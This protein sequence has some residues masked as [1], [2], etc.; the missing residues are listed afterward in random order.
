MRWPWVSRK[1]FDLVV[2]HCIELREM[3][4]AAEAQS[5]AVLNNCL[6]EIYKR[7]DRLDVEQSSFE[8]IY[9][10]LRRELEVVNERARGKRATH[11]VR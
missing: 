2:R 4:E 8:S 3:W 6:R 9:A 7:N 11:F 10:N 1:K 5:E